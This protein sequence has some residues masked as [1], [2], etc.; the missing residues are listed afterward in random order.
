MNAA[1]RKK[2]RAILES[3]IILLIFNIIVFVTLF[4]ILS[5]YNE[6]YKDTLRAKNANDVKHAT[7]SSSN[8]TYN[9]IQNK[10]SKLQDIRK[11]AVNGNLTREDAIAFIQEST[12]DE[13]TRFQLIDSNGNG[14]RMVKYDNGQFEKLSYPDTYDQLHDIF[15]ATEETDVDEIYYTPS[16]TDPITSKECFALYTR[17]RLPDDAGNEQMYTLMNIFRVEELSDAIYSYAK[18]NDSEDGNTQIL[19]I[20]SNGDYVVGDEEFSHTNFFEYLA[21]NNNKTEKSVKE[22][23]FSNNSGILSYLN[24]KGEKCAY[25]FDGFADRRWYIISVVTE[26]SLLE[27]DSGRTDTTTLSL[28]LMIALLIVDMFWMGIMNNRLFKSMKAEQ[29]QH[30]LLEDALDKAEAANRAKSVFLN[31]MSHDI[32]TPMNAII[33]FT[34]L[35]N[36]YI[37]NKDRVSDYL[38]KILTSSQHL[39]GLIN[40]VL[41]MSRIESG[42]MH[43]E[44]KECN[45]SEIMHSI[46]NMVQPNI[47]AKNLNFFIDTEDVEHENIYCDNLRLNQVLINLLSNAVK[48]TEPGGS[49]S[50]H[51]SEH[52][53]DREGF[54]SYKFIV[55]DT[56]IGM[57]EQFRDHIFEAFERERTSTISK[58]QGTGLGMSITKSIVDMMDGNITV[59][60]EQGK[61]SEFTVELDFRINTD[62]E[63]VN[64]TIE[65]LKGAHALVADD[66]FNTCDSVSKM[67]GKVGM[68]SE[69]T[70]H[71]K[72]A[73]LRA[74]KAQ[75]ENDPFSVYIID[76]MMPDM[77]GV[78]V[79]RQLRKEI[80][81]DV[82]I[83][84]LTAYDYSEIE[85][86]A[87]RAGVTG[88][89][90]K[91]MFMS[92]LT[93][94]LLKACDA[95]DT[96]KT[97]E[98]ENYSFKGSRILLVEDN[99]LNRE[100]AT[101]I[102]TE[103]G[104]E[105][106]SAEDGDVAVKAIAQAKAGYYDLILMDIQMPVMNGYEATKAI[107]R[108]DDRRK[109]SIPIIAMTANAFEEDKKAALECGM[110]GHISKPISVDLLLSMLDSF[111]N[112]D[113]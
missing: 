63:P 73:L 74:R 17:F 3:N 94:C 67:L 80:N 7:V 102:L 110:D 46:R 20:D 76:W 43:L 96:E 22:D 78:E 34:T 84:I 16:F 62:T 69:W 31:N 75:D 36:T 27:S 58:I 44:E 41:D 106:D 11:Y 70:M 42:K 39:L 30:K 91:P 104:F 48:F 8:I 112:K 29:N 52:Q 57:S 33:G 51:I 88:F 111:I 23:F 45:L 19:M 105:I 82:P 18:S 64:M 92:D 89:C 77:N 25:I 15:S 68:R 109:A 87:I 37:D 101:E 32:R 103:E 98:K 65:K 21:E 93:N 83:I 97:D 60:S 14:Y 56:G 113:H 81:E 38:N 26:N 40:D 53:S 35:A 55:R 5:F 107:R 10:S 90:S 72:E 24:S 108:L 59:E 54:A 85:D 100:I 49:V 6:S 12:A 99:E 50:V 13:K 9:F 47:T 2:R 28:I 86:E 71:G 1:N 79:V 61:G 95:T 66:D 4:L